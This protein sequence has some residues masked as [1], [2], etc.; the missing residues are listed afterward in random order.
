[1]INS[2]HSRNYISEKIVGR[3][4]AKQKVAKSRIRHARCPPLIYVQAK[5]L[6]MPNLITLE[7][8]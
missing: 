4:R 8:S 7:A 3:G 5:K 1:M 6:N 2:E